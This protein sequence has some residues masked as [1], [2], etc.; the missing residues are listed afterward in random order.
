ML[1]FINRGWNIAGVVSTLN[2]AGINK[3]VA[4]VIA[5][6]VPENSWRAIND[7]TKLLNQQCSN[8]MSSVF[9]VAVFRHIHENSD[10]G[11][12]D[13][14]NDAINALYEAVKYQ[15][16][17]GH[18]AALAE[19]QKR[20]DYVFDEK[21]FVGLQVSIDSENKTSTES[22][23]GDEGSSINLFGLSLAEQGLVARYANELSSQGFLLTGTK[24]KWM[25][26]RGT[27]T[28][29]KYS[30]EDLGAAVKNFV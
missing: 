18:Q 19:S 11:L 12:D 28:S 1:D 15:E 14:L 16:M 10:L 3:K 29:Y 9:A 6:A 24:D 13:Q 30:V 22:L 4:R 27:M 26:T 8:L 17:M 20:F 25:I 2:K 7:C 21:Y 5:K 23:D